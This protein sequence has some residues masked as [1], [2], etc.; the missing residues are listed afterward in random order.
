MFEGAKVFEGLQCDGEQK[1]SGERIYKFDYVT[2]PKLINA[3]ILKLYQDIKTLPR[4][5]FSKLSKVHLKSFNSRK[6]IIEFYTYLLRNYILS[7]FRQENF[8]S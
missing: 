1:F 6:S 7:I 3:A 2:A 5:V 8:C 4:R